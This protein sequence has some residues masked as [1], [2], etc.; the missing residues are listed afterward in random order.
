MELIIDRPYGSLHPT[1]GFRYDANYG[2]VPGT[3]APDGEELDAYFL[4]GPEALRT[5]CGICVAVVHRM[6]DDD[7]KLVVVPVGYQPD[8]AEIIAAVAFQEI[9]GRYRIVRR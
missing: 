5:A 1:L 7:D 3:I 2:Y 6:G 8:D 4:G 9:P